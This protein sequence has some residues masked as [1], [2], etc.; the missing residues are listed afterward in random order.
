MVASLS[1][2]LESRIAHGILVLTI[3]AMELTGEEECAALRDEL[4]LTV[5]ESGAQKIILDFRHV[6]LVASVA[7]RTLLGLR[8]EVQH[9]HA[10]MVIC[11]L[12][13]V[14][15]EVFQ[16]TGLLITSRSTGPLFEVK[17][18]MAAALALLSGAPLV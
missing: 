18:D 9:R 8:R 7:F 10:R 14:V 13:P 5:R 6:K 1:Q 17:P 3:T 15:A 4:V 12:S 2:S 11:N 16:A